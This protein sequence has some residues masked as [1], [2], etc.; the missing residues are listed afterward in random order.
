MERES[1]ENTA[2][3]AVMNERFVCVKVDR[4]ERPDI[5]SIYMDAL[6]AMTGRGGWPMTMFLT[7][8]AKPYF[9]GTYFPPTERGGM[10]SFR[11]ILDAVWDAW[12]NRRSEIAEQTEALVEQI[13]SQAGGASNEPL[14]SSLISQAIARLET[15]FDSVN[16]GFGSA[17]KF[18]QAPVLEL[19]LR[20]AA[21]GLGRS[22]EMGTLTLR[23]MA[24]GGIYDQLAGGFARYTV[25]NRWLV[26]HFEKMLYDNAQLSRVNTRAWQL[27]G[28]PLFRRISEETLDYLLSDMVAGVAPGAGPPK[29]PFA[30]A[31]SEDADSEGKEGKFYVWDYDEFNSIAPEAAGYYGVTEAGNFEG[32]NILT[33]AGE[34]PPPD[35]RAKL[36]QV[37]RSRVRPARDDKALV[38]W[39]GLAISA[40]AE[41][42]AAFGRKDLLEKAADVCR[43]LLS[44]AVNGNGRL[45]HSF[46]DGRA[47]VLGMLEDYAFFAEGL[48]SL[49]EG[50]F[51]A[52]WLEE[53]RRLAGEM[54]ELFW[55]TER[56][57]FFSTGRDHETLIVRPK[58]IIDGA[59]PSPNG[60]ASLLLQRLGIVTG[61]ETFAKRGVETLRSGHV[62]MSQAPQV[63][64]TLLSSLDF[65]LSR[66]KEIVVL[67]GGPGA[68][69]LRAEVW[70][71]FLPN[72]VV[73]GAASPPASADSPL[74]A[75]K[76]L[77]GGKATAFVCENYACQ[78]PTTDP[79]ELAAQLGA[80]PG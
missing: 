64:G 71:R 11:R 53:C 57:G 46:K 72:K 70:N 59:T 23:K 40:L 20:G 54:I 35:A 75:G 25:D 28:D 76:T 45:M 47:Q 50:T 52:R 74:L 38:S 37:R 66:P 3:A 73:A 63:A 77:L 7:P 26:P 80:P 60:V 55:D 48:L 13:R 32:A 44:N 2:T 5:D 10:P 31:A 78:A 39:N 21:A 14:T 69:L 1:F 65:Y 68:D 27:T 67:G 4:E 8:D 41:A 15:S 51:D 16:G 34:A 6:L 18:P 42:G 62:Y 30:F 43:F 29:G 33:A 19:C 36:L 49:W 61:E 9:G 12:H 58:E 17:P 79:S 22:E 56:G 24:L